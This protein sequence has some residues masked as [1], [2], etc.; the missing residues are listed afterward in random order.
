MQR[1]AGET[2]RAK[3]GENRGNENRASVR[4]RYRVSQI[5]PE[6]DFQSCLLIFSSRHL[7][8]YLLNN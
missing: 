7:Y 8:V 3:G 4:G 2:G 1:F 6:R 5:F